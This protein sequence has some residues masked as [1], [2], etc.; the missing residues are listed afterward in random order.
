[1]QVVGGDAGG[2]QRE[3]L[4]LAGSS[5]TGLGVGQPVLYADGLAG[6]I[7]NVGAAGATVRL[8]TD[9]NFHL[10][11][12]FCRYERAENGDLRLLKITTTPAVLKGIGRNRMRITNLD[13]E[14]IK[15]ARIQVGD[16][17]TL[18]DS[19]WAEQ[20]RGYPVGKIVEI[21][22]LQ[23]NALFADIRVEP[24]GALTRLRDVMVMNKTDAVTRGAD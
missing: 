15:T 5:E 3:T 16:W 13:M 10:M 21:R 11:G 1:M 24:Q 12:G 9:E 18:D 22:P 6:R 14:D 2:T 17:V 4:M 19:A 7:S 20:L 8:I 23:D